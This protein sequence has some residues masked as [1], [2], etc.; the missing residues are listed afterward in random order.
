M[1][2]AAHTT[3]A[4]TRTQNTARSDILR[5][6]KEDH[7]RVRKAYKAF[8]KLD[9]EQNPQECEA[10]VQQVLDELTLHAA[11]EEEF[12]YPAAREMI[13][14]PDL[15]DEAEVEHETMHT[16]IGQLRDMGASDE[17]FA[18][19]FTVLCEYVLHH[20]KEEEGE[21]FPKLEQLKLDW[22]AMAEGMATRRAEADIDGDVDG[23]GMDGQT[24][25]RND[26][27]AA[28]AAT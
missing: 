20:V 25:G 1:S 19:R 8:E 27:P 14:E 2:T 10:L 28:R 5:D 22:D 9:R 16:A 17:K 26:S 23:D 11:L 3:S 21:I 24:S 12:L 6:L 15:I 18:A 4:T 7:K 13:D